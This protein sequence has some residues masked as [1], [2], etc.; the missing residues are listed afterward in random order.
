MSLESLTAHTLYSP[1][2]AASTFTI[3]RVQAQD[4]D[5]EGKEE[6]EKAQEVEVVVEAL[7]DAR[8]KPLVGSTCEQREIMSR[9]ALGS[10]RRAWLLARGHRK[11]V[12]AIDQAVCAPS[13]DAWPGCRLQVE[14]KGPD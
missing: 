12:L 10:W 8:R 4:S 3:R 9:R 6:T 2:R 14:R 11:E 5:I 1:Q 7:E 13:V